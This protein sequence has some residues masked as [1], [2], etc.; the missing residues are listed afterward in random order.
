MKA[1]GGS[2]KD[3]YYN[4]HVDYEDIEKLNKEE[5][6]TLAENL[7][8]NNKKL[9]RLLLECW[10]KKIKTFA[11]CKGH[12]EENMAYLGLEIDEESID[13]VNLLLNNL[14]KEDYR[15]ISISSANNGIFDNPNQNRFAFDI[16]IDF[17][18]ANHLFDTLY[19]YLKITKK[20]ELN[21]L[22]KHSILIDQ[23]FSKTNISTCIMK[24]NKG[25]MVI[26]ITKPNTSPKYNGDL[27]NNIKSIKE[28]GKI[29]CNRFD[30]TEES[31][32]KFIRCFY[33]DYNPNKIK[34]KEQN[35]SS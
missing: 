7:S 6:D 2:M 24:S 16:Q 5:L 32:I 27:E 17:T 8:E 13:Y 4:G 26:D 18:H 9:K 12:D 21:D 30:C 25:N 28:K 20:E 15:I 35:F 19:S 22:L 10:K 23:I 3:K 14:E 34:R 33:K 1:N 31:L 11:C 29:I